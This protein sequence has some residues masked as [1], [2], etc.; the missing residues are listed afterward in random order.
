MEKRATDIFERL[1]SG[2]TILPG[3]P[4]AYRMREASFAT[5]KLSA[6]MNGCSDPAEIRAL[7]GQITGSKIDEST[8][9]FPPLNINYGK[10]T[11]IG[12]NVFINFDC[13]F[14]G[15]GGITIEDNVLIAPK[16]SLLSEGHPISPE[17]RQSLVPGH[18]HIKRNA[19]IGANAT[20]LPGVTIGENA[21]VAAGAV[22]SKDVPD[23]AIVGGVPAKVIK[24]IE[25][26]V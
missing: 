4:E 25:N 10:T 1:R 22:V 9:V 16:V 13:T 8:T 24:L 14:L 19:W 26:E 12:R 2:E 3:D 17:N 18:I 7:L 20:I 21:V 15:L 6:Q 5:M 11:K 23:N